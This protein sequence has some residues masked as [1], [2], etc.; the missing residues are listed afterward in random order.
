MTVRVPTDT[1]HSQPR[2]SCMLAI[3]LDTM[4]ARLT[5]KPR[6][7]NRPLAPATENDAGHRKSEHLI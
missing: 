4:S 6:M 5:A 1:T 3:P 2:E 7:L